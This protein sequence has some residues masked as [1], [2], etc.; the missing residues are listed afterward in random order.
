MNKWLQYE[1]AKQAW[2][3]A[4]PKSTP[5]EYDAFIRALVKKLKI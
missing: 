3:A 5:A 4:H 1:A 2:I